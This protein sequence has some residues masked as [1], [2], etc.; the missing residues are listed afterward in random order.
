MN[1]LKQKIRQV[2]NNKHQFPKCVVNKATHI[3]NILSESNNATI[4]IRTSY[5][6]IWSDFVRNK[7]KTVIDKRRFSIALKSKYGSKRYREF[8]KLRI[9]ISNKNS[10]LKFEVNEFLAEL[11]LFNSKENELTNILK[12]VEDIN[13]LNVDQNSEL[14]KWIIY[15]IPERFVEI[16]LWRLCNQK[17]N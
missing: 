13:I 7:P 5:I 15:L 4:T 12:F 10:L 1:N 8:L 2:L 6:D 9:K 17:Y 16:V 14:Y 11:T 3:Q